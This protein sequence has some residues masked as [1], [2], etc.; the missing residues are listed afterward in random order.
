[1]EDDKMI[2][3]KRSPRG[4]AENLGHGEETV[5]YASR[6]NSRQEE[7]QLGVLE[8]SAKVGSTVKDQTPV[9]EVAAAIDVS[10]KLGDATRARGESDPIALPLKLAD[11]GQVPSTD[12]LDT[13]GARTAS[14]DGRPINFGIVVPGVYRSSFPKLPDFGFIQDLRLKTIVYVD[15]C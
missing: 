4:Y 11:R 5:A 12:V 7:L 14:T 10:S 2:I 6:R 15:Q 1:M 3:S 9:R 13:T 8:T